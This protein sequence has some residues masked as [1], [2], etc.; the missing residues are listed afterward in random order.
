[1]TTILRPLD[2]DPGW[3]PKN[4]TSPLARVL[5]GDRDDRARAG[6]WLIG[7]L[8]LIV[9]PFLRWVTASSRGEKL[10]SASGLDVVLEQNWTL[11]SGATLF[12]TSLWYALPPI[13]GVAAAV[14]LVIRI[15]QTGGAKKFESSYMMGSALVAF[16]II[17]LR[18]KDAQELAGKSR[19]TIRSGPGMQLALAGLFLLFAAGYLGIRERA[20]SEEKVR[21]KLTM[22]GFLGPAAIL[23]LIYFLIPVV[24]LFVLSL[25]DLAS[26]NFSEP[27]TYIGFDNYRQVI[28]D[29]FRDRIIGN[30]FRYVVTTLVLFNV[31]LALL[32]AILTTHVNRRVGFAGRAI[33]LLPRITPPVVYVV[34]WQRIGQQAPFGILG[35]SLSAVGGLGVD[36]QQYFLNNNPWVFVILINGFVGASF[37]M[38]LFASAIESIPKDLTMAAK[39]DG[40]GTWR[41]I[42]DVTMPQLKF[43]LLFVT[44]YQT[45]SLLVSF[46]LILLLTDGGPG[47]FQTEVWALTSY[48]RALGSYFGANQWAS[49]AA[50]GF[51]LV[52]LGLLMATAYLK[53]FRF[54]ELVTEPKI[55][56]T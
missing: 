50:W 35:Q 2:E 21:A 42:R 28:N 40:A 41:I 19:V 20:R 53:L 43:P 36:T 37:G 17:M 22:V 52:S 51:I 18:L 54:R 23:V 16:T 49:G 10:F 39:V 12:K 15:R 8:A 33:W 6:L 4:E 14:L 48:N 5:A 11:A 9:S 24:I 46:E 55:E 44:A 26:S 34:M 29:P 38:I 1:M 3:S 31:G 25:T 45:L 7:A 13:I 47:L 30:T 56:L 32:L 27:W